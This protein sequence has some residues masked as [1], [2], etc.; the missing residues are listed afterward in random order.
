MERLEAIF[1]R[2]LNLLSKA[3]T[4][5]EPHLNDKFDKFDKWLDTKSKST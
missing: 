4:T 3:A 2:L 5:A 1:T